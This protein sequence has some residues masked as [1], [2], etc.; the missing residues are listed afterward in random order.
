MNTE[1]L[2][3]PKLSNGEKFTLGEETIKLLTSK[4]PKFKT[5]NFMFSL[6]KSNAIDV[7]KPHLKTFIENG[8]NINFYVDSDK[9]FLVNPLISELINLGCNIYTYINQNSILEFQYRGVIFESTKVSEIFFTSGN[10]SLNGMFESHNIIT[11]ISFNLTTDKEEYKNFKNNIFNNELT[12]N[13][14]NVTIENLPAIIGE[15][16]K[17]SSIPTISDFAKHDL[18]VTSDVDLSEP[19]IAIEINDDVNFLVSEE[20]PTPSKKSVKTPSIEENSFTHADNNEDTSKLIVEY[21]SEPIY[22]GADDA[23]DVENLLFESKITSVIKSTAKP[24][25][26]NAFSSDNFVVEEEKQEE[27][28]ESIQPTTKTKDVSKTSI[29]MFEAPKIT[30]KGVCA[31]EIKIPTYIRDLISEFWGWPDS[32]EVV[33]GQA[34]IKSRIC[35]FKII[36]TMNPETIL[37]DEKARLFQRVDESSFTV[38]SSVLEELNIEENDIIRLIK[39]S[40]ETDSY[41]TC[42][43][44]RK[45]AKEYPIWEQFC[46]QNFRSSTRKY[47]IM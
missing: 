45:N 20:V 46:T 7:L 21:S 16:K 2:T 27:I 15:L 38:Y 13:F 40:T 37:E 9:R 36:D 39:V 6:I 43:L 28:E 23:I 44:I 30:H 42:E 34:K 12:D 11:H 5:A 3:Q 47:G 17:T 4:K 8:G 25:K 19:N 41:Y 22:Y 31:G 35:T 24:I 18:K 14:V 1:I 29:F 33:G 32:Y 10:M 26:T